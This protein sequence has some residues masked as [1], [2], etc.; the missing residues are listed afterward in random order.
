MA[1]A[2]DAKSSISWLDTIEEQAHGRS[3]LGL[4]SEPIALEFRGLDHAALGGG[5][6]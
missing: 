1:C 2:I 5:H 3:A 6:E 4:N